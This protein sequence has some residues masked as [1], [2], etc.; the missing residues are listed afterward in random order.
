MK[1]IRESIKNECFPEFVKKFIQNYYLNL[2]KD[3]KT[4]TKTTKNE[5][6]EDKKQEEASKEDEKDSP[7]CSNQFNIPE[8][9]I[10]ALNEVNINVLDTS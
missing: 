9:V 4:K 2:N 6:P 5:E 8:W 1:R 10:N 7:A 3:S